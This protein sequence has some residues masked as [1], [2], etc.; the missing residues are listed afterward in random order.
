[1][2]LLNWDYIC[3]PTATFAPIDSHPE[4]ILKNKSNAIFKWSRNL[5]SFNGFNIAANCFRCRVLD[6]VEVEVHFLVHLH[7]TSIMAGLFRSWN[8]NLMGYS[9]QILAD[10]KDLLIVHVADSMQQCASE[11]GHSNLILISKHWTN[12]V[13][14]FWKMYLFNYYASVRKG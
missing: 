11:A 14:M 5:F 1:M 6:H 9:C 8:S 10:I 12:E 4:K 3:S 13:P 2:I 7:R